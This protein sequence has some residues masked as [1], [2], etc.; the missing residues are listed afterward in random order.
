MLVASKDFWK[1]II[2]VA[3]RVAK[4]VV[5]LAENKAAMTAD[6]RAL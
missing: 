2:T 5:L 1:E 6:R 3:E 4:R